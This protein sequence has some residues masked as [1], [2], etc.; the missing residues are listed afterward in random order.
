M[1]VFSLAQPLLLFVHLLEEVAV[2][3]V[4]WEM[5]EMMGEGLLPQFTMEEA[6]ME[7]VLEAK[8]WAEVELECVMRLDDET[9]RV[10]DEINKLRELI[11][12]IIQNRDD[13]ES[14]RRLSR[15]IVRR[16]QYITQIKESV[17]AIEVELE[18][19]RTMGR[20]WLNLQEPCQAM[21]SQ[22]AYCH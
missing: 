10:E 17:S 8:S 1:E 19:I 9:G 22:G 20:P 4:K 5:Q 12:E 7:L 18:T 16:R 11:V 14:R 21:G 2:K 15:E 13:A 6:V 3:E